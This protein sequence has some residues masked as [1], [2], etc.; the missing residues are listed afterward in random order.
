MRDPVIRDLYEK[1]WRLQDE[2]AQL[3]KETECLKS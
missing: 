3:R 1:F 2:I